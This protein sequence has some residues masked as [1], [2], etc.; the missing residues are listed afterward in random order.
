MRQVIDERLAEDI[1]ARGQHLAELDEGR[2]Q[3]LEGYGIAFAGTQGAFLRKYAAQQTY[4]QARQRRQQVRRFLRQQ[5]IITQ[6]DKPG[7]EHAR[8]CV[9]GCQ[10]YAQPSCRAQ[11]PPE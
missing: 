1:A 11:T 3:L 10:G 5:G 7:A 8:P 9:Q 2:S 6:Q 4:A